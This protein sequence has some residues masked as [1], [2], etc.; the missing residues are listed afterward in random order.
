M[1]YYKWI[2]FLAACL[3]VGC[4]DVVFAQPQWQGVVFHISDSE[5]MTCEECNEWHN[6]RGWDGCGY[7]FVIEKDGSVYEGRG[8]GKVGAH[9]KGYNSKYLGICFVSKDKATK[10]QL[11]TFERILYQYD[12]QNL[13]IYPHAN[14]ANKLCGIEVAKQLGFWKVTAYDGCSKCN[15]K[16]A[17]QT[18]MGVKPSSITLATNAYPLGTRLMVGEREYVVQ[19]RGSEKKFGSFLNPEKHVDLFFPTH[20]EASDFGVKYMKVSEVLSAES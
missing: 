4:D 9:T 5:H 13:P 17:G 18:S 2:F 11:D 7:N 19:D 3:L 20:E 14:F 6:A 1:K 16:F 15:G 8:I 12:L 10:E